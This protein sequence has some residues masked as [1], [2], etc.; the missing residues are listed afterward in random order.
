M[1]GTHYR[2]P[3]SAF[4]IEVR[5]LES[6]FTEGL[7][8]PPILDHTNSKPNFAGANY[9]AFDEVINGY[10]IQ[11]T[12][13]ATRVDVTDTNN[14][15]VDVLIVTG[16]SVVPSN[17]AGL[18]NL[19]ELRSTAFIGKEGMGVTIDPVG[20]TDS[21]IYDVG[22]RN[23]PCKTE[24]NMHQIL[25][26]WNLRNVYVKNNLQL[27]VNHSVGHTFFGDNPQLV[28]I[29]C[30]DVATYPLKNVTGCKF[31]DCYIT[32]E[33]DAANIIWECIVGSIQNANGFIYQSTLVGPI[34]LSDDISMERCWAAPTVA[35]SLVII[36]F[37][38]L[39][40]DVNISS[41]NGG[42]LLIKNMAAGAQIQIHGSGHIE[43]DNTNASGAFVQVYPGIHY[44]DDSGATW[45]DFHDHT[46]GGEVWVDNVHGADVYKAHMNRRVHDKVANTVTVYED[47]KVTPRKVFDA[48]DDLTDISPQ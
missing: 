8:A 22:T 39:A 7:W 46:I 28:N 33:L 37:D 13:V 10:T 45:A 40:V 20:G 11:F 2:L 17:S 42:R 24:V 12:G 9:V 38:N 14:N 36:D 15:L 21:T 3:M 6:A 1:S 32:G 35:A 26:D 27:N 4:H 29:N 30:G 43:F 25:A 34:V 18:V 5:R 41:F 16:V 48:D 31:Q 47:D 19:A 23:K 44:H